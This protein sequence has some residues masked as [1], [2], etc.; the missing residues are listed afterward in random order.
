MGIATPRMTEAAVKAAQ[1][2]AVTVVP[3]PV[4]AQLHLGLVPTL[5]V[6]HLLSLLMAVHSPQITLVH[7]STH[8]S[9]STP[10][11]N[12]SLQVT[13]I[14]HPG[15]VLGH[16]PQALKQSPSL[17]IRTS[18]QVQNV[19]MS[20]APMRSTRNSHTTLQVLLEKQHSSHSSRKK[21]LPRLHLLHAKVL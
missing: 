2:V 7:Q 16:Q 14:H 19:T 3:N 20:L 5:T 15:H 12:R 1:A 13:V 17:M 9:P 21:Y 4:L 18:L 6:Q 10:D 8:Q 11:I